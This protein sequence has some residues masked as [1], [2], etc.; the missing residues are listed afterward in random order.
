MNEFLK[1]MKNGRGDL[2]KKGMRKEKRK[3]I[4]EGDSGVDEFGDGS[5]DDD[6]RFERLNGCK[7][8]EHILGEHDLF[9]E[10]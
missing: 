9:L 5:F 4:V 10:R 6:S 2:L 7:I 3:E 8:L 1:N